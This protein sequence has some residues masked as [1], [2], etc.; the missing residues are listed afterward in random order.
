MLHR[1]ACLSLC[2]VLE[3]GI[4]RLFS[5][6]FSVESLVVE[7]GGVAGDLAT[8]VHRGDINQGN[9][10]VVQDEDGYPAQGNGKE[11]SGPLLQLRESFC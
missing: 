11:V 6:L 5:S 10:R 4:H 1:I 8:H 2:K 7:N 9:H 3:G